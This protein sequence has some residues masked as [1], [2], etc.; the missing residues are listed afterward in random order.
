[1]RWPK[2]TPKLETRLRIVLLVVAV[3][4][5][6]ALPY[7]IIRSS[8]ERMLVSSEWVVHSANVKETLFE[9]G[10]RM[11]ELESLVLGEIMDIYPGKDRPDYAQV[12]SRIMP[13]LDKLEAG[14]RDQVE[15]T[16]RVGALRVLLNGR[17]EMLD[18]ALEQARNKNYD[19]AMKTLND[20]AKMFGS[21]EISWQI[22]S[23][24][25]E[26][27]RQRTESLAQTRRISG[28]ATVGALLAQILLLG[29]VV[30]VSERQA[31]HR[32]TAE[33]LARM[34]VERSRM[35]V[36]TMREPIVVLDGTLRV[37]MANEAFREVYGGP[38]EDAGDISLGEVGQGSWDDPDLLQRLADVGA[39]GRE[40]WDYEL[41]QFNADGVER[42]VLVNA[43]RMDLSDDA[44]QGA[45]RTILL[46]ASDVT[47]RKRS[48]A[49]I[50]ELNET[51]EAQVAQVS[52]VNRELESFSYSVSH[53]LRA[54]L[55]HIA[56]FTDK[57]GNHIEAAAD[58]KARHYL[59]VIG[60][61]ARRMSVLIENL[62]EY[63][64]LGRSSLRIMPV[65]MGELVE[66]VREMLLGDDS[67]RD[68]EW[69]VDELPPAMGDEGMLRQVWQNL[70][71]N[72]IKYTSRREHARIRI[73]ADLSRSDEV[74]YAVRDNGT[75]FDMAYSKKLFGVFQ[76][77]HKASDFPGTGI[78]L[79][80]VRRIVGR[81]GGRV[82][83]ESEPDKGATFHFS[84][85]A[86]AGA[87][88]SKESSDES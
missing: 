1:M 50:R 64:R 84:L 18:G 26:L 34:A 62:L 29:S 58:D 65:D 79:A 47:A 27:F 5:S 8:A 39:R 38:A 66:D 22:V 7:A 28:W 78:G 3:A 51:L 77:L 23:R 19:A 32:R 60:D 2:L 4:A 67:Q 42:T 68:I 6:V 35:I 40:I 87:V 70:I 9:L 49:R 86:L 83:A 71:G 15:Q 17:L 56:G 20:G 85:P 69:T 61:A 43:R 52:E 36:Q 75:G 88:K 14:T 46:T 72:A 25:D 59:E 10:F 55:R 12:R 74:V 37:L 82:W 76:R 44:V 30:Y 31:Q 73:S 41:E 11:S 81:H 21:R 13:L 16:S 57:L 80:N 63:S 53:D 48:E 33:A 45:E 24:A 54:P